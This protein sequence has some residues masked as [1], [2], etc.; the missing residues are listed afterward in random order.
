M[1]GGKNPCVKLYTSVFHVSESILPC[2]VAIIGTFSTECFQDG[3]GA[4]K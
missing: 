1:E 3:D 2:P 4:R